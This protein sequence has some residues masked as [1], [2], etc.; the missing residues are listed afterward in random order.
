MR[1]ELFFVSCFLFFVASSCGP[2]MNDAIVK[3]EETNPTQEALFQKCSELNGIGAFI[4]GKTTLKAALNNPECYMYDKR[5]D[6]R[7]KGKWSIT[8]NDERDWIEEHYPELAR[9]CISDD[10]ILSPHNYKIGDYNLDNMYA[11]FYDGILVAVAYDCCSHGL[12]DLIEDKYGKGKGHYHYFFQ[13][14][15]PEIY[16]NYRCKQEVD[17]DKVWENESVKMHYLFSLSQSVGFPDQ[18]VNEEHYCMIWDK[19]LLPIFETKLSEAI[20]EFHSIS[21]REK[22]RTKERI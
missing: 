4:V 7:S 10:F 15:K 11:I 16:P 14:N 2:K 18:H 5:V 8:D 19:D 9:F 1:I 6:F 21:Q 22:E 13:D 12:Y 17:I 20:E 3:D